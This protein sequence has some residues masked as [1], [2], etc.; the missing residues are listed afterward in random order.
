MVV[1]ARYKLK[2]VEAG[3]SL[4]CLRSHGASVAEGMFCTSHAGQ[5][6]VG[7]VEDFY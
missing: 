6:N 1:G 4:K 7:V 3:G 5:R 2:P